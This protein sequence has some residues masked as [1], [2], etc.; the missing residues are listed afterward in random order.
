MKLNGMPKPYWLTLENNNSRHL[1]MQN[2]FEKYGIENHK[3]VFG[4][5]SSKN[6]FHEND[7]VSGNYFHQM[8]GTEIAISMSHINMIKEWYENEVDDYGIFFEDDVDLCISDM[9]GFNWQEFVERLP[10]NWNAIQLVLVRVEPI[11]KFGFEVRTNKNWSACAY[12]LKRDY[13]RRLIEDYYTYDDRYFLKLRGDPNAIPYAENV[14][15]FLGEPN[16]YTVPLFTENTNYASSFFDGQ[17]LVKDD[18]MRSNIEV[19]QW[20]AEIGK[21]L[22]IDK[23]MNMKNS[24]RILRMYGV[25]E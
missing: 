5:D 24:S 8:R 7:I 9:W 16:V 10:L 3:M 20:W 15:Y 14:I 23:I 11:T 18:N 4:Y 17:N 12:I 2:Q 19:Y 6:N 13:A 22:R 21:N 25:S 1:H